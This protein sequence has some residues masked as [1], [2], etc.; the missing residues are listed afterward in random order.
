LIVKSYSYFLVVSFSSNGVVKISRSQQIPT[1]LNRESSQST[2]VEGT[3]QIVDYPEHTECV[4]V[5]IQIKHQNQ[6]TYHLHSRIVNTLNCTLEYHPTN[7]QWTSS[8][9]LS[10]RMSGSPSAMNKEN[11]VSQL[12]S[13]I[14][15]LDVQ[16]NQQLVIQTNGQQV[17]LERFAVAAPA[18]VTQNI[19]N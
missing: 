7:N 8:A 3:W 10:T 18:A 5:Q 2:G 6:N 14:Q 4:G 15:S 17:Q 9:V 11:K 16:G 12:I 1:S 13:G 19:F